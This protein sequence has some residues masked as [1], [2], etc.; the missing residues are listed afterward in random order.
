[1]IKIAMRLCEYILTKKRFSHS[2]I[3]ASV[4]FFSALG[5]KSFLPQ[6][7]IWTVFIIG[8]TNF[9]EK[10]KSSTPHL[11][12]SSHSRSGARVSGRGLEGVAHTTDATPPCSP[13]TLLSCHGCHPSAFHLNL[14]IPLRPLPLSAPP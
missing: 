8:R 7:L 6:A 13:S 3:I 5:M 14:A 11:P 2:S 9:D 12:T 1:M 10:K 4:N